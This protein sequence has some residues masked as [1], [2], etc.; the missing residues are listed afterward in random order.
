MSGFILSRHIASQKCFLATAFLTCLQFT[1]VLVFF[2]CLFHP[3]FNLHRVWRRPDIP[4]RA[5]ARST[6]ESWRS[7]C[8][9][10]L[11]SFQGFVF[12]SFVMSP[13]SIK[14]LLGF[15]AFRNRLCNYCDRHAHKHL[16]HHCSR[17]GPRL[18]CMVFFISTTL[19]TLQ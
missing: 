14:Q 1:Y 4:P 8:L 11:S 3:L 7:G 18:L 12:I 9:E 19:G 2:R 10:H 6:H 13:E 17:M 16:L 5:G 15:G